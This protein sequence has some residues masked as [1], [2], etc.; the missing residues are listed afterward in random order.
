MDTE[1]SNSFCKILRYWCNVISRTARFRRLLQRTLAHLIL[2]RV[3]LWY[4]LRISPGLISWISLSVDMRAWVVA[5]ECGMTSMKKP[6]D[7]HLGEMIPH[8]H[9]HN[10]YKVKCFTYSCP[11]YIYYLSSPPHLSLI[12]P[13]LR[14][15][16]NGSGIHNCKYSS[17]WNSIFPFYCFGAH[18]LF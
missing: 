4:I 8:A 5:A 13:I 9:Q 14:C 3:T 17:I 6:G 16:G 15:P 12:W 7:P 10:E 1:H 2:A 11:D 18:M